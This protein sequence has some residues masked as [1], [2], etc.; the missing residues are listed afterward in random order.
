MQF[1]PT[2]QTSR[3]QMRASQRD[4]RLGA[5]PKEGPACTIRARRVTSS[6]AAWSSR[7]LRGRRGQ[8]G[9]GGIE[10]L[11]ACKLN[12]RPAA[13]A[14]ARTNANSEQVRSKVASATPTTARGHAMRHVAVESRDT[15]CSMRLLR[16]YLVQYVCARRPSAWFSLCK[17]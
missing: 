5:T 9:T 10:A 3:C 4:R 2:A 16:I 11:R 15:V 6:V 12:H 13:T 14:A 17:Q 7:L 1:P 8:V